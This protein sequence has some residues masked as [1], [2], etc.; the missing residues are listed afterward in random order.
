MNSE[1]VNP[2]RL[3]NDTKSKCIIQYRYFRLSV[4]SQAK[5][6]YI[7]GIR[8]FKFI[9]FN[10][11]I[12]V[13]RIFSLI[14]SQNLQIS[15]YFKTTA[16]IVTKIR[17]RQFYYYYSRGTKIKLICTLIMTSNPK[18]KIIKIRFLFQNYCLYSHE[19]LYTPFRL[20][21]VARKLEQNGS[22]TVCLVLNKT[23]L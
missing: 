6:I 8:K 10:N 2:V 17:V 11:F 7:F 4:I 14:K 22:H 20:V 23:N 15:F 21:Q 13:M 1:C 9:Y 12:N 5:W 16:S 19:N 3:T 18:Y